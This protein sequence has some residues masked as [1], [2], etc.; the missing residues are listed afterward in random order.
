[1]ESGVLAT[2]S[3]V[4]HCCLE[5][6]IIWRVSLGQH[7]APYRTCVLPVQ[8]LV[9][10]PDAGYNDDTSGEDAIIALLEASRGRVTEEEGAFMDGFP[11]TFRKWEDFFEALRKHTK[12]TCQLLAKRLT[13]LNYET[14]S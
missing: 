2:A 12:T 9:L 4:L 7:P 6:F 1:M 11:R 10:V 13:A 5:T 3:G 14:K 8:Q